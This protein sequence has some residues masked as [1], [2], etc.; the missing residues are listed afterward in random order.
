M[1]LNLVY[2]PVLEFE[3]LECLTGT[4]AKDGTYISVDAVPCVEF[5][6]TTQFQK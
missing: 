5:K 2:L 6:N 1:T 3:G 4:P